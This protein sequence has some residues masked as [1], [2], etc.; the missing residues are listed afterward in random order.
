MRNK[1][2]DALLS[3]IIAM[4]VV[5]ILGVLICSVAY[6]NFNMKYINKTAKD[7]FYTAESVLDDVC[8]KL[9]EKASKRYVDAYETVVENYGLYAQD[10]KQ[11]EMSKDLIINFI[12]NLSEELCPNNL[13]ASYSFE[14]MG[15]IDAVDHSFFNQSNYPAGSVITID[16]VIRNNNPEFKLEMFG[17][18]NNDDLG[19]KDAGVILR[20]VSVTY[21]YN[22]YV[23]NIVTD[24]RVTAPVVNFTQIS[25]APD[26]SNFAYVAQSGVNIFSNSKLI[27]QGQAY[28]GPLTITGGSSAGYMT[29]FDAT[30]DKTQLLIVNGDIALNNF[31]S[32][33]TGPRVQ[34]WA[35]NITTE[36]I[37]T[38][39]YPELVN[40]VIELAGNS[41][42]A[43]DI[44]LNGIYNHL[45]LSGKYFGYGT[46]DARTSSAIVIN[47]LHS[48]IDMSDL[49]ALVLG[50]TG[51]ISTPKDGGN[52]Q[53][54]VITG[55]SIAVKGNQIAYMLPL[56]CLGGFSNPMSDR[57]Y[58]QLK[59]DP[60]WKTK[61]VNTRIKSIGGSLAYY[62]N[63]TADNITEVFKTGIH[64]DKQVYVFIKFNNTSDAASYFMT[65]YGNRSETSAK[66]KQYL[67]S[68]LET[69]KFAPTA[70]TRLI[71]NGNFLTQTDGE[72]RQYNKVNATPGGYSSELT[73]YAHEY[74]KYKTD[75]DINRIIRTDRVS[76]VNL[77]KTVNGVTLV[78]KDGSYEVT[79]DGRGVII[80]TGDV[81]VKNGADW[82]GL[83]ICSGKLNVINNLGSVLSSDAKIVDKAL[84]IETGL[85]GKPYGYNF[86]KES[87]NYGIGEAGNSN[88]ITDIRQ[89][90]GFE[91]Y[92]SQ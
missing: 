19:K 35:E 89:C 10:G 13:L 63:Y 12:V 6:S 84:S 66:I 92:I 77:E 15:V 20:N 26:I 44:S 52:D 48:T 39:E 76:G 73:N 64:N 59:S 65:V 78:I 49:Q 1:R 3:V 38:G 51:Y 31:A 8:A 53:P 69:I 23:N 5:G 57:E 4:S 30:S 40:D 25:A 79:H 72:K 28:S 56:E 36:K 14:E 11:D 47:G 46:G 2:G 16:S 80:S 21:E 74:G 18:Q 22:G 91:N 41:Y 42:I 45:K 81:T 87:E 58:E 34:L 55:E 29:S 61:A 50:G 86:F 68:Y 32:F 85:T 75:F 62:F 9:E 17:P 67:D 82:Q 27:L 24:I 54:D 70:D 7:N 37:N 43:D 90:I 60:D 83:I 88:N 33:K 71:T